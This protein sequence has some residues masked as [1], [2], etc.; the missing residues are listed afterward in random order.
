MANST[1][2][3]KRAQQLKGRPVCITLHDGRSYVGWITDLNKEAV[4]LS[5]TSTHHK[6]KRKSSSGARKAD[7]S[8]FM[9]LLGSFMG[10]A[11]GAAGIGGLGKFMGM[12][13]MVQ[14][15]MPVM[16]MGYNM[17]KSIRPFLGGLKGLMG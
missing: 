10:G 1:K 4:I 11:G 17:I 15:A 13:G 9:P 12:F 2:I 6:P 16:K 3:R 5:R 14:K 8:G 7:V